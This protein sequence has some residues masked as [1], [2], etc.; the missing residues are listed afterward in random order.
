MAKTLT[1]FTPTY[2]RAH[3]LSNL[4]ESLCKQNNKNFIWLVVDDGSI[5][6]TYEL[7]E[8]WI[9]FSPF[10]IEY[11]YQPNGGKHIA[12]N[13]AVSICKT[14]LFM[15]VDSDDLLVPWAVDLIE[16]YYK[17]SNRQKNDIIGWCNRR[18]DLKGKPVN[19]KNWPQDEPR[20]S[21]VELFE[22]LN[23]HG[24]TSLV[25]R[26]EYLKQYQFPR[27]VEENFVTEMVLYYQVSN[28]AKMQLKNDIFYLF[29]YHSDGYTKAGLKL[30]KGNPIGTAIA[31]KVKWLFAVGKIN[32]ILSQVKY[33]A[34]LKCLQLSDSKI[35]KYLQTLNY[36]K[37]Q[38][39]YNNENFWGMNI[40]I[41]CAEYYIKWKI[42]KL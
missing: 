2:N 34:W 6:N 39:K 18:G 10:E 23:F 20:L 12:H 8:K 3:F 36:G 37:N 7:I 13:H 14:P 16:S 38:N 40:L 27:I 41:L 5:D 22:K 17:E 26:T 28:T 4:W 1:I 9:K 35:D 33:K 31:F 30:K 24:E 32:R 11:V 25:W 19:D 21:C 15:C 42:M 29:E